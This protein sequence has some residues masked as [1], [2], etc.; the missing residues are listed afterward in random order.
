MRKKMKTTP[1]RKGTSK[2][3]RTAKEELL[4]GASAYMEG[5]RDKI[6]KVANAGVSVLIL[7]ETGTGKELIAKSSHQHSNRSSK[8]FVAVNWAAI[9]KVLF[10]S[11]IFG[12][13]KGSFTGAVKDTD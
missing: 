10:E 11:E 12:Y 13:K 7:G 1:K 8:A 9:P 3:K 6:K 5:I 4:V 2:K